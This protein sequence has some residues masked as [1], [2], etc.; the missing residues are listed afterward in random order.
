MRSSHVLSLMLLAV[1]VALVAGCAEPVRRFP[2]QPA[3]WNDA[4]RNHVATRPAQRYS[5]MV[6]DGADQILLR[7]L[8]SALAVRTAAESINVNALDEVPNSAWFT[9]RIGLRTM[10]PDQVRAGACDESFTLDARRGPWVVTGAKP[11]GANPGFFITAPDGS[12]YLLKFDGHQQPMRA[13]SGDVVGSKLYHA[14]GY[15]TPCNEIVTFPRGL[16]RI[17]PSATRK[18]DYGETVPITAADIG[19]VLDK[20]NRDVDGLLRA[21]ASRFLPGKPLG[22][23]RYEG[24][25][26]DDPNDVVAH[27][28]RRELRGARLLAAWLNHFDSREQNSLDLWVEQDGRA[29]VRH[30]IIDWGDS[31]GSVWPSS[32]VTQRLGH[33]ALMSIDQVAVDLVSLGLVRRPWH[34]VQPGRGGETFGYFDDRGFVGSQWRNGLPN[35]AFERMTDSDAAW[36]VRILARF[37]DQRVRAAVSAARLP[38]P[39]QEFLG[40]VLIARRDRLM[41]EY[42]T[43]LSPLSR[44]TV[45][46]APAPA[47]CFDDDAVRMGVAALAATRYQVRVLG[48]R[49]LDQVLDAQEVSPGAERTCL[50][51]PVGARR[52]AAAVAPSAPAGDPLRY[53]VVEVVTRQG[54]VAPSMTARLHLYD[55]GPAA[56]YR[57]AGIERAALR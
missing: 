39:K 56:G 38:A 5:G 48:G 4:D 34:D 22:P 11:D 16:L 45:T 25:R 23:F 55:L 2:L 35:P 6:G 36:A 41:Q 13:T 1:F 18:N 21:S 50:A 30:Y 43:R 31:F 51:L 26:A 57:L 44:F 32:R 10:S 9:N 29:F 27:D 37:D 14:F 46:G 19:T 54:M 49:Q 8:A 12:R 42:L 15:H 52:P 33:A 20:A 3:L 24:T 17:S 7:P 28:R 40:D 53:T 47:L